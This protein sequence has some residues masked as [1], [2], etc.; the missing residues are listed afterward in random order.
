MKNAAI[1]TAVTLS[2]ALAGVVG[3][4][5]LGPRNDP[6]P[7]LPPPGAF[8]PGT[9]RTVAEPVLSLARLAYRAKDRP[10]VPAPDRAEL[11]RVQTV[12]VSARS[13]APEDL[14]DALDGVVVAIGYAR[15]R[16]DSGTFQPSYLRD[17][18]TARQRLQAACVA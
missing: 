14:A 1:A 6:A 8:R 18:D 13:G 4:H 10:T 15:L 16:V 9:C 5:T 3:W 11:A 12:L 17:L 2:L 7:E